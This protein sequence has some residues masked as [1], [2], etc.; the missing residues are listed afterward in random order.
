MKFN[1]E[2]IAAIEGL[3]KFVRGKLPPPDNINGSRWV[4]TLSGFAGTG[5]TTLIRQVLETVDRD[6]S[7]KY[8]NSKRDAFI[9]RDLIY[10][11]KLLSAAVT[12]PTTRAKNVISSK[13]G[14]QFKALTLQSLL[15]LSLNTDLD[16]FDVNKPEFAPSTSPKIDNFFTVVI[17]EASMTNNDLFD[18]TVDYAEKYGVRIIFVG[19]PG[20]CK[21]V[22]Q[23]TISKVFTSP[24]VGYQ[25]YVSKVE[26]QET[27]NPLLSLCDTI[28]SNFFAK[29]DLFNKVNSYIE[30]PDGEKIGYGFTS[31]KDA[32]GGAIASR[33]AGRRVEGNPNYCKVLT[34]KNDSV[35][36]WNF[37]IRN[38]LI[39]HRKMKG[40]YVESDRFIMDGEVMMAYKNHNNLNIINSG[41]YVAKN[42]QLF[43]TVLEYGAEIDKT[44]RE[45]S[46]EIDMVAVDLFN[47]DDPDAKPIN[48]SIVQPTEEN[49]KR[50]KP[51]AIYILNSAKKT[52]R[53]T[54]Y[55][56]FKSNYLLLVPLLT[57]ENK[58]IIK[59][60]IDYA[61]ALTVHKSQGSTYEEVYI[62]DNNLSEIWQ[63][64]DRNILKYVAASRA[65]KRAFF[66]IK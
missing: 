55:N 28:R 49:Y 5:K 57:T 63:H 7:R 3:I 20:Q 32:F 48:C 33:F 56:W 36:Y 60:D 38:S 61:Y 2:Q 37:Q 19:D 44:T 34:F 46:V 54:D 21:P 15:G 39:A 66:F 30:K 9:N 42:I 65:A 35:Q 27:D 18:T 24:R 45:F 16:D 64:E 10:V 43:K 11:E 40:T 52:K 17:D 59:K 26:R 14:K 23:N 31:S 4:A 13:V 6:Y 41:E 12:A 50:L 53:W 8:T 47:I 25:F 29:K 62:D 51:A 1:E 22:K 58:L